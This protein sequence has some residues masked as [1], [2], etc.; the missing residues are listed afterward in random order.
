ME[1]IKDID[2]ICIGDGN[3]NSPMFF[4][5]DDLANG[6]DVWSKDYRRLMNFLKEKPLDN[7][8]EI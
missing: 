4:Y 6:V 5:D 2:R 8:K 1:P 3:T 7:N